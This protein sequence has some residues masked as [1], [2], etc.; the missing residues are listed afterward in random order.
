MFYHIFNIVCA[1]YSAVR[2]TQTKRASVAIGIGCEYY[3]INLPYRFSIPPSEITGCCD[4]ASSRAVVTCVS[5]YDLVFFCIEPCYL[6]CC[7][8]CFCARG[9]KEE[10][11]K[12]FRKHFKQRLCC[13]CPYIACERR[14]NVWEN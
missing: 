3:S 6:Y 8:I 2:V 1:C 14:S 7:F 13:S 11:F 10:F 5:R 12:T 9:G 4:R